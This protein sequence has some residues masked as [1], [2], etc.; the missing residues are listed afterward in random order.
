MQIRFNPHQKPKEE[1]LL[2]VKGVADVR[3][4]VN[5]IVDCVNDMVFLGSG[6]AEIS[7]SD[8]VGEDGFKFNGAIDSRNGGTT[9][10]DGS[11]AGR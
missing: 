8:V 10:T 1:K 2:F 3:D 9:V 6:D 5:G 4:A 11:G 7:N